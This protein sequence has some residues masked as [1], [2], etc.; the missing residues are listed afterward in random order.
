MISW[1]ELLRRLMA[2]PVPAV[3]V[4]QMAEPVRMADYE[5]EEW[6][7][8]TETQVLDGVE[9]RLT[10]RGHWAC[11]HFMPIS[12]DV[13]MNDSRSAPGWDGYLSLRAIEF[14]ESYTWG[15]DR[16]EAA[17]YRLQCLGS[18]GTYRDPRGAMSRCM[19]MARMTLML[20]G[21]QGAPWADQVAIDA[22][23]AERIALDAR[24]RADQL[25]SALQNVQ[26]RLREIGEGQRVPK[27]MKNWCERMSD[28]LHQQLKD[29]GYGWVE[30]RVTPAERAR[31]CYSDFDE[32]TEAVEGV[33]P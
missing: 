12:M 26:G 6:A 27:D 13:R 24:R 28:L 11:R 3:D 5:I 1:T 21:H 25:A 30:D 16:S 8:P 7:A 22:A 32:Y 23:A 15:R 9:W 10:K 19:L 20:W 18:T 33:R 17:D 31:G 14:R 2:G 29:S 4:P